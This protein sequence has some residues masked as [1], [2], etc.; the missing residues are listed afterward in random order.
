MHDIS[1]EHHEQQKHVTLLKTF[2]YLVKSV[3]SAM[4]NE[5]QRQF[6]KSQ[7]EEEKEHRQSMRLQDPMFAA[8]DTG[9][10]TDGDER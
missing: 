4:N 6:V 7:I 3:Y 9:N 1:Y 8:E 5:R 10:E 2:I